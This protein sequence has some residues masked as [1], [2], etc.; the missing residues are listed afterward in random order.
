MGMFDKKRPN[1]AAVGRIKDLIKH[2]LGLPQ[3]TILSVVELACHEPSCPHTETIITAIRGS[4]NAEV[5][6]IAISKCGSHILI[7]DIAGNV[8]W[9]PLW[10]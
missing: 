6:G 7:G 8:L 9:A 4:T 1:S 2:N 3:T 5:S 10:A